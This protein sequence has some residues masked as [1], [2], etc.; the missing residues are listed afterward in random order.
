MRRPRTGE[1]FGAGIGVFEALRSRPRASVA[2]DAGVLAMCTVGG[3][4]A[5]RVRV[6]DGASEASSPLA[7]RRFP[8]TACWVGNVEGLRESI[9]AREGKEEDAIA[10]ERSGTR[11]ATMQNE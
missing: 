5:V 7:L 11:P 9:A 10:A 8:L 6:A 4:A 1:V 3:G 2:G